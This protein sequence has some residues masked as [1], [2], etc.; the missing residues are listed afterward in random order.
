[1]LEIVYVS[2]VLPLH[3]IEPNVLI[4]FGII[5]SF[6]RSGKTSLRCVK[7]S[8]ESI[9]AQIQLCPDGLEFGDWIM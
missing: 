5:K 4:S 7:I 6:G 1:M 3:V 2:M 8:L 9:V